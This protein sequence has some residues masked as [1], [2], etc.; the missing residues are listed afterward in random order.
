MFIDTRSEFVFEN[1]DDIGEDARG[2]G[3]I[4]VCPGNVLDDGDLD[5]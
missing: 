2:D 4:L 3:D 1:L 5:W